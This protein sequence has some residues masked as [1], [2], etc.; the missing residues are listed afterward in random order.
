V[1]AERELGKERRMAVAV[2]EERMRTLEMLENGV[3]S[4]EEAVAL[5][6]ALETP[7]P[8]RERPGGGGSS[9]QWFRV[10]VTD[11]NSGRTKAN[12]R[13]PLGI[14][15]VGLRMGARFGTDIESSA[16]HDIVEA[17]EQGVQGKILEAV[18]GSDGERVEIYVE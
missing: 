6:A 7:K 18:D 9:P 2:S 8:R 16:L 5:L 13:I 14:V 17:I 4:A 12:V 15:D 11:S 10:L 1:R 3:I